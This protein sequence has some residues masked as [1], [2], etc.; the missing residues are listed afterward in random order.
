MIAWAQSQV[1]WALPGH[2]L[3]IAWALPGWAWVWLH[4]CPPLSIN[5]ICVYKTV[6]DHV[7]QKNI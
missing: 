2:C 5:Y 3:G 6:P 1:A 4:H 7:H